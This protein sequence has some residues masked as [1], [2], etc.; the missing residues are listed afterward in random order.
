MYNSAG[1]GTLADWTAPK[2]DGTRYTK[3]AWAG[4]ADAEHTKYDGLDPD[5]KRH[6]TCYKFEPLTGKAF[7]QEKRFQTNYLVKRSV[8]FPELQHAEFYWPVIWHERGHV[9]YPE[10][11]FGFHTNLLVYRGL[12]RLIEGIGLGFG[13]LMSLL[14]AFMWNLSAKVRRHRL[15]MKKLGY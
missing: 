13:F 4:E 15:D 5:E 14:G 3:R 11:A 10:D 2:K 6:R 12:K 7:S 1:T 9:E 8:L